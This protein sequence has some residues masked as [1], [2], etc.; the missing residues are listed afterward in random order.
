MS[1]VLEDDMKKTN[2]FRLLVLLLLLCT[3]F[4]VLTACNNGGDTGDD[5]GD[6]DSYLSFSTLTFTDNK[7][8]ATVSNDT[9][10]FSFLGEVKTNGKSRYIVSLDKYG[11]QTAA[12]KTVPLNVG[13]NKIY[14]VE[15]IDG[16][17]ETIY[18][19]TIRRKPMYTVTFDTNGGSSVV[20]QT[21]EEG[22]RATEPNAPTRQG[23]D[24]VVWNYDFTTPITSD[25]TIES[26]WSACDDTLY[27]VEYYL[28][29]LNDNGYT[30]A[31]S[32]TESKEG[33]TDSTASVVAKSIEH[34]TYNA[35]KSIASGN[36]DGNGSLVLKLYYTRDTYTVTFVGGEGSSSG[37]KTV[38]EIKYGGS[39]TAP[40]FY[41]EGHTFVGY[42]KAFDN[43]DKDVTITAEWS[44]NQY[45]FTIIY[46]NGQQDFE[47]MIDY[48]S[49]IASI[50]DPVRAGYDFIGWSI[51]VLPTTMPARDITITA[52]WDAIFKHS[53]GI[54]TGLTYYG[55]TRTEIII[56]SK[57][58]GINITQ[59][60]AQAFSF[61]ENISSVVI[62]SGVVSIGQKAFYGCEGLIMITIPNSVTSMGAEVFAS[63][64]VVT[65][66]CEAV[67]KPDG[68]N[69]G[70]M[71]S[72]TPVVWDCNNNDVATDGGIYTIVDG[73]RYKLK[74]GNATVVKQSASI[75]TA[76]IQS[77][78]IYKG[79][80]YSVTSID[81][82]IF[83]FNYS[84]VSVVLPNGLTNIS[85]YAFYNCYALT[86][87]NIPD[88]VVTV[89]NKAFYECSKVTI[90]CEAESKPDGWDAN[91]ADSALVLWG[92]SNNN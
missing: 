18:E 58:D 83:S 38:Q 49:E 25:V 48:G 4:C 23:Y 36:I 59:I 88:S 14:I 43:I 86:S 27:T 72:G 28:Q 47:T 68:W 34:F 8:Y 81:G 9:D 73:I 56:P 24:F 92:Q 30:L 22:S 45:K 50:P 63:C 70:W 40:A 32:M 75:R 10:S 42:D 11:I 5:V 37:G 78:I 19:V 87:I 82:K 39:A 85:G 12:T 6:E 53:D 91:W 61:E 15:M 60:G 7:A 54:I 31:S 89:G 33:T 51:P 66:Y 2:V 44:V 41:K 76:N 65:I 16:E 67:A 79:T 57:I 74:D 77:T 46:D 20:S 64:D 17:P 3:C 71:V 26:S 13:D 1:S 52:N 55:K 80:T 90:Y 69:A 29:N 35:G 84:L 62:P 21:I